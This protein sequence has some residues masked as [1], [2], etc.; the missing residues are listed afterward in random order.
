[1]LNPHKKCSIL[2][3]GASSHGTRP[4]LVS[5]PWAWTWLCAGHVYHAKTRIRHVVGWASLAFAS[6]LAAF[7]C[8]RD[9][10][11]AGDVKNI[12]GQRPSTLLQTEGFIQDCSTVV[13]TQVMYVRVKERGIPTN[14]I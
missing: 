1:M 5:A 13:S 10:L 12:Y 4:C 6:V 3:E 14:S 2:I 11:P 9:L 8:C 7:R